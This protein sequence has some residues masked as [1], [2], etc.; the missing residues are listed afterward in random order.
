QQAG[1]NIRRRSTRK[2]A[3]VLFGQ[4]NAPHG[5]LQFPDIAG[6]RI[7]IA[8]IPPLTADQRLLCDALKADVNT[9]AGEIGRRNVSSRYEALCKAAD[10]I[11]HSMTA[12]G[13]QVRRQGY[14]P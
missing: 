4:H 8:S 10:M 11:E 1:L 13:Y 3:L 2:V 12:A 6:P 7:A 14:E 9:L 5:L